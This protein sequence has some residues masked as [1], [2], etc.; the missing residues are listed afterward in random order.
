MADVTSLTSI[1]YI[2]PSDRMLNR[3]HTLLAGIQAHLYKPSETMYP[4]LS[5]F[6]IY[7]ILILYA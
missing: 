6:M 4:V 7:K 5:P 3:F 1:P 2:L